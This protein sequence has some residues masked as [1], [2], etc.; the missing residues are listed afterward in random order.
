MNSCLLLLCIR[1]V[2]FPLN[3]REVF[4]FLQKDAHTCCK[5]LQ[6]VVYGPCSKQGIQEHNPVCTVIASVSS[7]TFSWKKIQIFQSVTEMFDKAGGGLFYFS[8]FVVLEEKMHCAF[9]PL[10]RWEEIK[11]LLNC[12]IPSAQASRHRVASHKPCRLL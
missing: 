1:N 5:T 11:Q 8:V 12:Q 4:T 2:S 10:Q 3:E 9:S 6:L 7:L